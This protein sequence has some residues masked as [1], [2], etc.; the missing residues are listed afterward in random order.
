MMRYA[1]VCDGIGAANETHAIKYL[2]AVAR[3]REGERED[4]A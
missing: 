4:G 2:N 3:N 1:S